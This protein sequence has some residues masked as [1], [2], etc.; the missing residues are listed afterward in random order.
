LRPIVVVEDDPGMREA[1]EKVL[2]AA[3]FEVASFTSAEAL[4]AAGVPALAGCWVFD[5]RLPGISGL[6]LYRTLVARGIMAP[7]VFITAFDDPAVREEAQRLG[8]AGF[9]VK[10]FGGRQLAEA[11]VVVAGM[12]A[13]TEQ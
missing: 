7:V 13:V 10:P 4:L 8:A 11:V 2:G 12:R 6:E 1:L 5:V 3:G 9:L